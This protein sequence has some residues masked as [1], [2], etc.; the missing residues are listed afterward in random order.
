MYT[1]TH[2]HM[3]T[4]TQTHTHTHK[5]TQTHT[6]TLYKQTSGSW[7]T[8]GSWSPIASS[9]APILFA[10]LDVPVCDREIGGGK[11]RG[12][13]KG[14][15]TCAQKSVLAH[16]YEECVRGNFVNCVC[17]CVCVCVCL[18]VQ[19]IYTHNIYI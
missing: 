2:T 5:H 8:L 1:Q 3:Y 13:G 6:H 14:G 19:Y 7:E 15:G 16:S 9:T 18:C 4:H 17:V 10:S 11:E 12:G